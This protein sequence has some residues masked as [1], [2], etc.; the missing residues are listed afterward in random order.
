MLKSILN[1]ILVILA[2]VLFLSV[3]NAWGP[4]ALL[5]NTLIALLALKVVGWLG[6]RVEISIWSVLILL[7]GG[8]PGLLILIFLSVTGIAFK[9]KQA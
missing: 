4:V 7:I 6:I 3:W 5:I 2:L 9:A 1:V 8:T